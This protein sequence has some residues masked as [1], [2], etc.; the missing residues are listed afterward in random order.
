MEVADLGDRLLDVLGQAFGRS[1]GGG[2][3]S[4]RRLNARSVA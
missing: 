1:G 2:V 3:I 4:H